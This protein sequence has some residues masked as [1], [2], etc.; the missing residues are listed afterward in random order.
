MIIFFS[1]AIF[2]LSKTSAVGADNKSNDTYSSSLLPSLANNSIFFTI[3]LFSK[4][5]ATGADN[6]SN[7]AYS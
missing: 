2:L 1:F 3:A 4:I 5:S 7:D 6:T